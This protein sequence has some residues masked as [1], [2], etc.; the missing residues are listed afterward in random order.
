MDPNNRIRKAPPIPKFK[1]TG[2]S[3]PNAVQAK[4]T[5]FLN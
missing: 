5:D 1:D 2:K 3:D 4:V